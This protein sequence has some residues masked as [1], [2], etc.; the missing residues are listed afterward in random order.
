MVY[1][2]NCIVCKL[3]MFYFMIFMLTIMYILSWN[4]TKLSPY[5]EVFSKLNEICYWFSR[6]NEI[7]VPKTPENWYDNPV[8]VTKWWN[9]AM[10]MFTVLVKQ[11][12]MMKSNIMCKKNDNL[13]AHTIFFHIFYHYKTCSKRIRVIIDKLS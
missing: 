12:Q 5:I 7:L 4:E 8:N 1:E 6:E 10:F 9:F 2:L 13:R 3:V 11:C